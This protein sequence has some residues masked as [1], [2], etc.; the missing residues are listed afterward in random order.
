MQFVCAY[1]LLYLVPHTQKWPANVERHAREVQAHLSALRSLCRGL[2]ER[3][4]IGPDP[5]EGAE[6]GGDWKQIRAENRLR[7]L[8]GR[9]EIIAREE[10]CV[11]C[12]VH[13][14]PNGEDGK[15][16]LP[17]VCKGCG[18]KRHGGC[19]WMCVRSSVCGLC[20]QSDVLREFVSNND[21]AA[22]HQKLLEWPGASPFW[23]PNP[24]P[25]F[26]A[27]DELV[28]QSTSLHEAA[29]NGRYEVL[30]M[31]LHHCRGRGLLPGACLVP[32][33]NGKT[34]Y[35][36]AMVKN[37]TECGRLFTTTFSDLPHVAPRLGWRKGRTRGKDISGGREGVPIPWVNEVDDEPFPSHTFTYIN[38]V[39]EGPGASFNWRLC[40][41]EMPERNPA[42][43][44][45][46]EP[47][48]SGGLGAPTG[49]SY[50]GGGGVMA[51]VGGSG[52]SSSQAQLQGGR[53]RIHGYRLK[54]GK[55]G[56]GEEPLD[57]GL[58][59]SQ[60]GVT[61]PLEAFKTA[62]KGWGV[63]ARGTI[64]EGQ[65]ICSYAG[66]MIPESVYQAREPE[67][68]RRD[69]AGGPCYCFNV[70]TDRRCPE[71]NIVVDADRYRG[72]AALFN[73]A[74][75]GANVK[76][77]KLVANNTDRRE[78]IHGFFALKKIV[79]KEGSPGP[80][81][82]FNYGA[83]EKPKPCLCSACA[84]LELRKLSDA[85]ARLR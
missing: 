83:K 48:E 27:G 50:G 14:Q 8:R 58:R 84:E 32:D 6:A 62:T 64:Q 60:M 34:A 28:R 72:V 63:R 20:E 47:D 1:W 46:K 56:S 44:H 81:L 25:G 45:H 67:Y 82:V 4:R 5:L 71:D 68:E 30:S 39:V 24:I 53:G 66:E 75:C 3:V 36:I 22:V 54:T 17:M 35:E 43:C 40:Y 78:P 69:N 16:Y 18:M 15:E 10:R 51:G 74:C 61:A 2:L 23:I 31:L 29:R 52:G 73:H 80:E 55:A 13:T 65:Y 26:S 77:R 49:F 85:P 9:D 37:E 19:Q 33:G 12:M 42:P 59:A 57:C 21:M 11:M 79:V 70:Y 7:G 76:V 41:Y 38:R